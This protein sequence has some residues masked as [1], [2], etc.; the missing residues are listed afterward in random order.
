MQITEIEKEKQ[1]KTQLYTVKIMAILFSV[2]PIFQYLFKGES[3]SYMLENSKFSAMI[4][5]LFVLIAVLALILLITYGGKK[6]TRLFAVME[7][8]I[9]F[10]LFLTA[11]FISGKNAS[12]YKFIFIFLIIYGTIQFSLKVGVSIAVLSSL[13]LFAIDYI[14]DYNSGANIYIENDIALASMFITVA[15]IIGLYSQLQ[16]QHIDFLKFYANRDGLTK[17]YNHRYFYEQLEKKCAAALAKDDTVSL[18]IIDIDFFKTYNDIYGH[19]QGD[20]VLCKIVDIISAQLDKS[21][22]LYRYG[23]EEFSVILPGEELFA[24]TQCGERIRCAVEKFEFTGQEALPNRNLTVSVGAAEFDKSTDFNNLVKRADSALYRAKH[25]RRNCVEAFSNI[26]EQYYSFDMNAE[27]GKLNHSTLNHLIAVISS[28]DNYTFNH[29]ERVSSYCKIFAQ[30]LGLEKDVCKKLIL[31]AFLHDIGKIN[32]DTEILITAKKLTDEQWAKL[33]Q[34]PADSAK[35]VREIGCSEEI[36]T[37][38]EQHHERID[39]KGYPSGIKGD[40]I[41]YPAKILAIADSFDAMTNSRPYNQKKTFEEAYEELQKCADS[42]FD[43]QLV[44]QFTEAI[45]NERNF[46][47]SKNE[48]KMEEALEY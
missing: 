5:S 13:C 30:H 21:N 3:L 16:K 26:I 28:K 29:M 46:Q 35:M 12:Y 41:C 18:L 36:A 2:I 11:I 19:Q 32:I 43:S 33:R 9:F 1:L 42:Q 4:A 17:I 10:C 40:E 20:A 8:M 31:A 7:I 47:N 45:E 48:N 34:H 25:L 23:G 15:F 38:V 24:A 39:G 44:Q 27:I 22:I 6:H 37:I 14:F